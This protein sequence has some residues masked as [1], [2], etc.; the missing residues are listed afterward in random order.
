MDYYH[1]DL[2]T[3]RLLQSNGCRGF[4]TC[5]DWAFNATQRVSN[6]YLNANQSELLDSLNRVLDAENGICFV[7]TDFRLE[8]INNRWGSVENC[9]NYYS[10]STQSKELIVFS[11]EWCFTN[12]LEQA[13][14]VFRWA[15]DNGFAF[16]FPMNK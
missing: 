8:H 15:S 5:D 4:L 12:Y 13:D 6:Y 1:A 11:H 7:K 2:L 16:D 10:N 9:L 14:S 3:C